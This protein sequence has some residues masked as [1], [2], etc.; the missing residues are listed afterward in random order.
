MK[1]SFR[2][3]NKPDRIDTLFSDEKLI[4]KALQKAIKEAVASHRQS[5]NKLAT[6]KNGKLIFQN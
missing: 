5:G 6:L 3:K 4:T 1:Q 2:A